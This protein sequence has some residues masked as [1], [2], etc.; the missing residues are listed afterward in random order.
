MA[1]QELEK[2]QLIHQLV[3]HSREMYQASDTRVSVQLESGAGV[4]WATTTQISLEGMTV[5]LS[6]PALLVA[7]VSVY[8]ELP[9]VR[10]S[11][12]GRAV[13]ERVSDS[14]WS[15]RF[16]HLTPRSALAVRA[17]TRAERVRN[18]PSTTGLPAIT[19]AQLAEFAVSTRV[20]SSVPRPAITLSRMRAVVPVASQK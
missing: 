8:C 18:S 7:E 6:E 1:R 10:A 11:V 4:I 12:E 16:T 19:A 20:A 2:Q 13:V 3:P 9:S 15:L 17:L 5:E 14:T